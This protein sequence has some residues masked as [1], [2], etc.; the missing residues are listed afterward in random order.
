[1]EDEP[2]KKENY[3]VKSLREVWCGDLDGITRK[4]MWPSF[5]SI[6]GQISQA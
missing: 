2:Y 5:I 4:G 3:S 1:M 6:T